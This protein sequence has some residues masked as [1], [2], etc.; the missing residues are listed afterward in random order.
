MV[1]EPDALANEN[2]FNNRWRPAMAWQYFTVCLSDFIAFP[3]LTQILNGS[4]HT[5]PWQSLTLQG[6]GL[7]HVAMGGI[8]GVATYMRSQEKMAILGGAPGS[9]SQSTTTI[10]SSSQSRDP[11]TADDTTSDRSKRDG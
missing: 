6:G 4:D 3:A 9:T 8:I 10:S 11:T 5:H 1:D 7:Y 2:W